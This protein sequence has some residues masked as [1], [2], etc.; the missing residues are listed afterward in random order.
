M[1]KKVALQITQ[2]VCYNLLKNMSYNCKFFIKYFYKINVLLRPGL[3]KS[4]K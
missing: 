2:E 3:E 1:T 4:R